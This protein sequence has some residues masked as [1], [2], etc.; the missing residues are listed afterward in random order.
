MIFIRLRVRCVFKFKNIFF[1]VLSTHNRILQNVFFFL[2]SMTQWVKKFVR[3]C[4]CPVDVWWSAN[5]IYHTHKK[6]LSLYSHFFRHNKKLFALLSR[7]ELSKNVRTRAMFCLRFF[8]LLSSSRV[9]FVRIS[10]CCLILTKTK[11]FYDT[12]KKK[13][14]FQPL[15][16]WSGARIL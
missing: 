16:K 14:L 12:R 2:F 5:S 11:N 15:G 10:T 7:N 6:L 9:E 1:F 13:K 8:A 3:K 4:V